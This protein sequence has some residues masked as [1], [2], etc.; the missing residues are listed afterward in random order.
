MR[1]N[2]PTPQ[3]NALYNQDFNLWLERTIFLLKEGK[4]LEVDYINLIEELE[5][6][7]RSEKNAL[8]SN[9]R[10]LL[11]HLLKYQFQPEKR[12][13]SWLYTI[14]EHRQRI[15]DALETSPSLHN[16]LG[17]VLENCYQGGKRLAVD[18]TGL[19]S[20]IFPENC[21]YSVAEILDLDYF[22]NC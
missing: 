16:F 9:L 8:K 21:P 4:L 17:E 19:S 10:I 5:S 12:T 2:H 18:E 15:T 14:S 3:T 1:L 11:M 6:M 22:P 7:G 20:N 13:N